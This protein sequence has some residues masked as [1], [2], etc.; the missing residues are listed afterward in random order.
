MGVYYAKYGTAWNLRGY[1]LVDRGTGQYRSSPTIA[2]G[3]FKI[4]KDGGT[5][6]NLAT[7]PSVEP[8]AGS[9]IVIPFSAAEM[10]CKQA[11]VRMVDAAGAQW[12]DDCIHIFTV[13][14]PSAHMQFDQFAAT[15]GL[16]AAS[17]S[18]VVAS[19]WGALRADYS[20]A[21][22]TYGEAVAAVE[23]GV[24][25]E[26]DFARGLAQAGST[27][28]LTLAATASS[29]DDYYNNGIL[30]IL[31]GT[32]AGQARRITD[33]NGTTKVATV[34]DLFTTAPD[35]TST[36]S[37]LAD[38]LSNVGYVR[39]S[40]INNLVSGKI[41]ASVLDT[42]SGQAIADE[43]LNRNLAGGGSGNSRNVRNALRSIRNR[44]RNNG[45]TLE[46]FEENDSTIAWS[47]TLT[48]AAG[49]P[50]TEVD[51]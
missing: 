9:S 34:T 15:V 3:D 16:S 12:N 35:T 51:P 46:V 42:S 20:G 47:A 7:L 13:G 22:G 8:A 43:I 48:T 45:G 27:S 29:V 17:V 2:A 14:D 28:T 21:S 4:E 37:I 39:G 25:L 38:T 44:V 11:V 33:Y 5:A 10:Q 23:A 50:I 31:T 41:D 1:Q 19:I 26:S 49:N 6:V 40:Q 30:V 32:G 36:Y 24:H 18:Q